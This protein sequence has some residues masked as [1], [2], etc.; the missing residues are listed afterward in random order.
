M[1][2]LHGPSVWRRSALGNRTAAAHRL[3]T[4]PPRRQNGPSWR[5]NDGMNETVFGEVSEWL[6]QAGLAGASEADIVCGFCDRCVAAGL[7][8]AR[9]LMFVDTLH[10]VHEGRLVRWGY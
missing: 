6:V 7:P 10:P 4:C 9:A 3:S 5:Y 2:L 1:V 8:L